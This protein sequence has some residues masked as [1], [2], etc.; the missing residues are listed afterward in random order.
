[1]II[2]SH[3]GNVKGSDPFNEN[4]PIHIK[5]LLDSSIYVEIDVWFINNRFYLGHDKPDYE[6]TLVFLKHK[7][8]W[9]HAKNLEALQ[10]LLKENIICFWHQED[11]FTLTSNNYIWTYPNKNVGNLSIIVDK[12]KD[13]RSKNYNC[14]GIC[15]DFL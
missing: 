7:N 5:K 10:E 13:W 8:L 3:R 9:C 4:N 11:D 2:I 6:I 12:S 14:Y 1:M 15:V